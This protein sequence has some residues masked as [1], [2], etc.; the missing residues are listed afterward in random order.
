VQPF[1]CHF[2]TGSLDYVRGYLSLVMSSSSAEQSASFAHARQRLLFELTAP[3]PSS[4]EYQ[5]EA[6]LEFAA[7]IVEQIPAA[8]ATCGVEWARI[9]R[10]S[11]FAWQV[12]KRFSLRPAL[13]VER[14]PRPL[15]G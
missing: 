1:P 5:L 9:A 6:A 8:Q 10:A 2:W 13:G 14:G 15:P 4:L 12:R 11:E 3:T 7:S